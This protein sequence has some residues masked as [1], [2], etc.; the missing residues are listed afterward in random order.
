MESYR[1]SMNKRPSC[2]PKKCVLS[3]NERH[4]SSFPF[5]YRQMITFASLVERVI[6]ILEM[7]MYTIL[8]SVCKH[9]GFGK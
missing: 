4:P 8:L 7:Q 5:F 9:A 1:K 3:S 6:A 2:S